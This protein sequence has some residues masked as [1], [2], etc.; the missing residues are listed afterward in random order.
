MNISIL[1]VGTELLMGKTLNT[2][3]TELSKA[4]NQLG[5]GVRYHLTIGDNPERLKQT[6]EFLLSV[7][8]MVI[9]TGG[10][11]PTQDDLTKE[12]I[13]SVMDKKLVLDQKA[14][15]MMLE[16]FKSFNV[17]M[18]ENNVIQ[19]YL[20]ENA[21]VMYN[22][23]GTAPGFISE[24]D[25][26]YV[27]ALPGPPREMRHMFEKSLK[28][29]LKDKSQMAIVSEYIN[30][31]GI[32]EST[33]ENKIDDII[34]EQ[35]NP[36]IAIYANIGQVSLR[37]T[38]SAENEEQAK[39]LLEPTVQRIK[40]RLGDYIIGYGEKSIVDYTIEAL[41]SH[42]LSLSL[43]ESCTGGM[44]ASEF[45]NF[46]GASNFFDRS[47]ITYSNQAKEDMIGV[48]KTTLETYGAVS[49][50]TCREMVEGVYAQTGSDVCLAVTGIAGPSGGS[51]E[52][53]VGLVYIGI[54]VKD[55]V[56]VKKYQFTGDRFVIRK[57]SLL[58][59]MS[60]ILNHIKSLY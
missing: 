39:E 49:P 13:A 45:V 60:M 19:S 58:S 31:F 27:A 21:I 40:D 52:K 33:A 20:P 8:D 17:K 9:T 14:H 18:T 10:L 46:P 26:K 23:K 38:A 57:R 41:M 22:E 55:Q 6:L 35:T 15:D 2:N 44:I 36:T 54:K 47:Y 50:E 3:A 37:V 1:A 48:S 11:G 32:G 5:H 53:P 12:T 56:T 43:A 29:F 51:E 59:S 4:I 34:S 28:A 16:R 42:D 7:S 25:G 24:N 30:L